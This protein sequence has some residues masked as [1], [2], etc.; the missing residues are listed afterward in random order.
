MSKS[1][2]SK[3][4]ALIRWKTA[5]AVGAATW[6]VTSSLGGCSN[7][8]DATAEGE[9]SEAAQMASAEGEGHGEAEG[10][11]TTAHAEGEGEGAHAEGEGEGAAAHGEGEG[12]GEGE[13]ATA[14]AEGEGEG[15]GEGAAAQGEGEGEG[16]GEGAGNNAAFATD[17]VAYLTQLGL[18]RGHLGVGYALYAAELPELAQT[19][20]KHPGAE[21]YT[22]I[23][24]AL[25]V[26]GCEG[27]ADGLTTLTA[28][29]TSN[30]ALDEVTA[31]YE[32]LV[33]DIKTCE[34]NAA[35]GDAK[36]IAG[37]I[38][39][40]GRT[41]SAE[42]EIG[43]VDGAMNILHEYQDA[44]GFTQIA[45]EWA[46]SS[47]FAGDETKASVAA[48]MQSTMMDLKDLWPSLN[49]DGGVDGR[50]AQLYGAAGQ[51]SVAAADLSR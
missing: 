32:A 47:A 8:E 12:E 40:L 4:S 28:A 7:A 9:G 1:I 6:I 49:P 10:E 39:N 22:D 5:S 25:G 26:R 24:S 27:F 41:A 14:H 20:M 44:W 38:E 16:E 11:G 30:A 29:V 2:P 46:E 45:Q 3:P 33:A 48:R 18:I 42:Y 13:G 36:V 35:T 19:H 37:V 34:A 15:E 43:V 50:A 51:I 31:T 23:E 21:I 17:D